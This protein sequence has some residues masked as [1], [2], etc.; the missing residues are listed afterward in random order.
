M[1]DMEQTWSRRRFLGRVGAACLGAAG[2]SAVGF[3]LS[4]RG[5]LEPIP[6]PRALQVREIRGGLDLPGGELIV[7]TGDPAD[8]TRGAIEALGGM[9]RFVRP[10]ETV[11]VK[12]NIGWDRTPIQAANTNPLVVSAIV[13][14]C[15]EAGAGRVIVTDNSCNEAGRCFTRSGIWRA[16]EQAGA[17]VVLPAAEPTSS[18]RS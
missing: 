7:A 15:I 10:G 17:Q 1:S 5:R 2:A 11:V 3:A 6:S 12:P 18:C 8:A 9:G 13:A 16:C 14:M 4:D